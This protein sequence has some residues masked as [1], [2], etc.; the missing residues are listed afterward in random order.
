MTIL[1]KIVL[2]LFILFV[3]SMC[4]F[5]VTVDTEEKWA[6]GFAISILV[7]ISGLITCLIARVW[8]I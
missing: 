1:T 5:G 8:M 6:K 2:T 4:G 7:E 3:T